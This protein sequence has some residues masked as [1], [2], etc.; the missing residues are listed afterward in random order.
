MTFVA[1]IYKWHASSDYRSHIQRK[2]SKTWTWFYKFEIHC[3]IMM[4][5]I[6]EL[7]FDQIKACFLLL[8]CSQYSLG[9]EFWL[10]IY[11]LIIY[12]LN[13]FLLNS[14]CSL[15][16]QLAEN[17]V[18]IVFNNEEV[19]FLIKEYVSIQSIQYYL[20]KEAS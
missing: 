11:K 15:F 8:N 18:Y 20:R 5:V 9:M 7:T 4:E 10:V 13:L 2:T 12:R 19:N 17:L 3:L 6:F 16:T 14:W 1:K